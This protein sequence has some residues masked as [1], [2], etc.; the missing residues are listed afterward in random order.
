[1]RARVPLQ[2]G[3]RATHLQGQ[4]PSK[5]TVPRDWKTQIHYGGTLRDRL[6]ARVLSAY[7]GPDTVPATAC[8]PPLQPRAHTSRVTEYPTRAVRQTPYKTERSPPLS[9]TPVRAAARSAL[10]C[11]PLA[12]PAS[13]RQHERRAMR[14]KDPSPNVGGAGRRSRWDCQSGSGERGGCGGGAYSV[15]AAGWEAGPARRLT[16]GRSGKTSAWRQLE[17]EPAQ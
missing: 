6:K 1:M 13:R 3:P 7:E 9:A 12:R 5:L 16:R 2:P 8:P 11:A 15:P 4:K 10:L 17:A 14:E